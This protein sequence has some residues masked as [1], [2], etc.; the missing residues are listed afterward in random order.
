MSQ[1]VLDTSALFV[2]IENEDGT[3]EVER[4]IMETLAGQHTLHV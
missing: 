1:Y 3:S 4:V 2:Y